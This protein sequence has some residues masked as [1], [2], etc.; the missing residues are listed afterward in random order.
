MRPP[1]RAAQLNR[2]ALGGAT[3][4][5]RAHDLS[6]FMNEYLDPIHEY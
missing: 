3:A 1:A 6:E 2:G 4:R 5:T